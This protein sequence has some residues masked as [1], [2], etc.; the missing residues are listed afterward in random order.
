MPEITGSGALKTWMEDKG[1][2]FEL[3][4][5]T[6]ACFV[7]LIW[8]SFVHSITKQ[9]SPVDPGEKGGGVLADEMG[10]GKSLS[11][12]SLVIRTLDYARRWADSEILREAGAAFESH[13]TISRATLV[14]VPSARESHIC[15]SPKD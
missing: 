6:F 15:L 11:M 8:Y 5:L 12:L 14:I 9:A 1:E 7:G 4:Q 10:M 2:Y 13:K 3:R